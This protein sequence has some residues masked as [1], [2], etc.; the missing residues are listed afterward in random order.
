MEAEVEVE[1]E[2]GDMLCRAALPPVE[3]ACDSADREEE[4]EEE[5]KEAAEPFVGAF[6]LLLITS[7]HRVALVAG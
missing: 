6:G 7:F 3:P 1:T 4:A 2:V 5:V